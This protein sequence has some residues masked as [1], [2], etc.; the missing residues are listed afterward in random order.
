MKWDGYNKMGGRYLISGSQLGLLIT[1]CKTNPQE[2]NKELNKIIE[3]Q[4]IGV[5]E[6]LLDDD[7]KDVKKI[8]TTLQ[9][10]NHN[11]GIKARINF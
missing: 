11:I 5:S 4:H 1:L 7:I 3:T 8:W 10:S 6:D 9:L 2:A